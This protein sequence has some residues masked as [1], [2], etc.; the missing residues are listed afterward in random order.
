MTAA[1]RNVLN[2]EWRPSSDI[3]VYFHH[4]L[5]CN[6]ASHHKVQKFSSG[7][8]SP[9]WSRKKGRKTVVVWC[10]MT[11]VTDITHQTSCTEMNNCAKAASRWQY[12]PV[13]ITVRSE[14]DI[15]EQLTSVARCCC[16][17]SSVWRTCPLNNSTLSRQTSDCETPSHGS[18]WNEHIQ[19]PTSW[20]PTCSSEMAPNHVHK[21]N[22]TCTFTSYYDCLQCLDTVGWASGRAPGLS[23]IEW[24]DAC[25]VICLKWGTNDCHCHPVI[26]YLKSRL[27]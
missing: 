4:S 7:T 17:D 26:S 11:T 21:W 1:V 12:F 18:A 27:V 14:R 15:K 13:N 8:G 6:L 9:R 23:K 24:W 2:S 3:S 19:T 25:M 22:N 16:E 5:T 10:G 20:S